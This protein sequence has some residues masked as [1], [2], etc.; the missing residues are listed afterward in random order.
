MLAPFATYLSCTAPSFPP[1]AVFAVLQTLRKVKGIL[2]KLTPEKFDRLLSQLIPLVHSY[3]VLQV[4][5]FVPPVF[6]V[7]ATSLFC[8]SSGPQV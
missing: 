8:W 1:L 7:L 4:G 2:N 6:P 3:E 5:L